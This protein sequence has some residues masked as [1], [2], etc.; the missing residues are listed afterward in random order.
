[1]NLP[2]QPITNED[3]KQLAEA[4]GVDAPGCAWVLSPFDTWHRNPHYDGRHGPAESI[5]HPE[6][7]YEDRRERAQMAAYE[8]FAAK[9]SGADDCGF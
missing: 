9:S 2:S 8:R 5:R 7:D 1:M 4:R 6:D 3:L